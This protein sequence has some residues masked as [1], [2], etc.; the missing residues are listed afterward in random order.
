[1]SKEKKY[2]ISVVGIWVFIILGMIMGM[3]LEL[4]IIVASI[5]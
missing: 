3:I 4:L 5:I 1:M 2:K